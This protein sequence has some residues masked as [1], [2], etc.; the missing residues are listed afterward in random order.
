M[1]KFIFTILVMSLGI[2]NGF[3]SNGEIN[4]VATRTIPFDD[5]YEL[6]ISNSDE[7][8]DRLTIKYEVKEKDIYVECLVQNFRFNKEKAGTEK[9]E[10]EGHV[11]LYINDRK[12]DSIFTPSFIIKALPAGTYKIKVELVHNDYAPY[13]IFKEFEIEL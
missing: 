4:E 7:M 10:G 6:M 11:Q 2:S 5:E 13:G 8:G 3:F 12:V 9:Q 1:A